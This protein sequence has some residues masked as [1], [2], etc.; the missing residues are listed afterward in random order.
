[1]R[2]TEQFE[3]FQVLSL[4]NVFY[5]WHL[6]LISDVQYVKQRLYASFLQL[7]RYFFNQTCDHMNVEAQEKRG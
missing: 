3:I 1:M 7:G 6:I 5:E 2:L 4:V